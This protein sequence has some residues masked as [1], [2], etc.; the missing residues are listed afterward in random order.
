MD[1]QHRGWVG[2]LGERDPKHGREI[3]SGGGRKTLRE[4]DAPGEVGR[5]P[6]VVPDHKTSD[7]PNRV[8]RG[9]R[10]G[11]QLHGDSNRDAAAGPVPDHRQ[12]PAEKA[13]VPHQPG[14]REERARVAGQ[15][16]VPELGTD[17]PADHRRHD[18]VG[19]V[20]LVPVPTP[21]L[22]GQ[23]PAPDREPHHHQDSE[24]G[25][26]EGADLE[27]ERVDGGHDGNLARRPEGSHPVTRGG[28]RASGAS[29]TVRAPCRFAPLGRAAKRPRPRS[30]RRCR[31]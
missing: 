18:D 5:D 3:P 12:H 17:H 14:A 4:L 26:L 16:H 22:E 19:S 30:S 24:A 31:C 20:F 7:P 27:Q 11:R 15:S 1:R 25:D 13:T 28:A 21:Q 23:E 8:G 10:G 2:P 6:I 29:R 9:E